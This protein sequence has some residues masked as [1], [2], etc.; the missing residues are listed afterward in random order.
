METHTSKEKIHNLVD[1]SNDDVLQSVFQLL[2]ETEY[3]DDFKNILNDEFA[4]YQK[5]KSGI[6]KKSLDAFF[7]KLPHI[8]DGLKF[9]KKVRN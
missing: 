9:Q 1:S 3:T 8:Q 6:S 7:G 5:N 4:D 2:E